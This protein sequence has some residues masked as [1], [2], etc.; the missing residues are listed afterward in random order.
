MNILAFDIGGTKISYA[1]V[2]ENGHLQTKVTTKATP[3]NSFDIAT[4]VAEVRSVKEVDKLAVATAGVVKDNQ[5][6]GKPINLP[7]GYENI[8]FSAITY[9]P[10]KIENDANAA[11]WAEHKIGAL[12]GC[13][14]CAMLTLGTGV[15]CG[16]ILNGKIYRG[17]NGASGE[18]RYPIAGGDLAAIAKK[19]GCYESDCFEIKALADGGDIQAQKA[20][21]KWQD[22]FVKAL[23]SMQE[24]LDLE[25]FALSGSLAKIVDY[26]ALEKAVLGQIWQP[27]VRIL[28][29]QTG[30]DAGLIGAAMLW[31]KK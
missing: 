7:T 25:A 24:I 8:D 5:V 29:A 20:L 23:I 11:V 17:A 30:A 2:D 10:C 13:E 27:K 6:C 28:P 31:S 9:L 18:V 4:L 14:N 1:V 12:K 22:E 15:G 19:C 26:Q 16:L 3:K 21:H